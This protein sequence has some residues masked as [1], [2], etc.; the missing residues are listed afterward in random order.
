MKRIG[1]LGWYVLGC[2]VLAGTMAAAA[3]TRPL[4]F[5]HALQSKDYN[6]AAL[7]YINMLK[8]APGG[9]PQEVQQVLDLELS[10][11]YR[12][13]ANRA[14]DAKEFEALMADAQKHLDKF[15]KENAGHPEAVTASFSWAN[16]SVDRA[17]Q[18]LRV[19]QSL[20]EKKDA[21]VQEEHYG[22]ARKGLIDAK[23][24]FK[25]AIPKFLERVRALPPAP[26]TAKTKEDRKAIERREQVEGDYFNAVFQG[27]LCDYYIGQTYPDK[28]NKNRV[29]ALKEAAAVF[30]DIHQRKRVTAAGTVD[31]IGLYAHMWN[32]R[33][34]DELGDMTMAEDIYDEV[35]ANIP[36]GGGGVYGLEPLFAQVEH[37]RLQIVKAKEKTPKKFVDEA[38]EWL[39]TNKALGNTDG[40]QGI[41]L[42]L[43]K[44]YLKTAE[45]AATPSEKDRWMRM[46]RELLGGVARARS[47][48][49]KEAIVLRMSVTKGDVSDVAKVDKFAEAVA[50]AD[51]A[52]ASKQWDEALKGYQRAMELSSQEKDKAVVAKVGEQLHAVRLMQ[53]Y[54]LFG[55]GK[56]E[57]ALKL[58]GQVATEG[59]GS[60]SSAP[61][62]SA[63]AIQAALNLYVTSP[64]DKRDGALQRLV[65]IANYTIQK[66]PGK[67]EADE[68]RINLGRASLAQ[69]K[70][71]E[72]IATFEAVNPNSERYAGALQLA[73]R[74]YWYK[75]Q[76]ERQKQQQKAAFNEKQMEADHKRAVELLG[77]SY[78]IQV[79][80]AQRGG[81]SRDLQETTLALANIA[82]DE[83]KKPDGAGDPAKL[84][85]GA[86]YFQQLIDAQK[87]N[88]EGFDA[89]TL[90]IFIGA[91]NAYTQL[92]QLDKAAAAGGL[93]VESGPDTPQVNSVLIRF[94][95]TLNDQRK[96]AEAEVA[97]G[98]AAKKPEAEGMAKTVGDLMR[99][100]A[101]R[102]QQGLSGLVYI[103]DTLMATGAIAEA[104][105]LYAKIGERVQKEPAFAQQASG[106][107]AM[108]RVRS[109]LA[110]IMRKKAE[111]SADVEQAKKLYFEA[112][113][114]VAALLEA[115][116]NRALEP[117]MEK[118]R[119]LQS[120]GQKLKNREHYQ[121]AADHWAQLQGMLSGMLVK[122]KRPPEYYEV[123]YN[124]A[125]C[126]TKVGNGY[127]GSDK[128][129]AEE[130][131]KNAEKLLK[132]IIILTPKLSGEDMVVAYKA[133][134]QELAKKLEHPYIDP[135]P[136]A[137][138]AKP[139]EKKPDAAKADAAKAATTAEAKK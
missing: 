12:G 21:K 29:A 28:K 126:M 81:M 117:W 54:S 129:R 133:L 5:L 47:M 96:K 109:Q 32:G 73:G 49:Q 113:T 31:P 15:L 50:L 52:A 24:R 76:A 93:L 6:D 107:K 92:G 114:Q 19:A 38:T 40:Y 68:A 101:K 78:A 79:K 130:N 136:G 135:S 115:T 64:A 1:S 125:E 39:K 88:T 137:G 61:A 128:P 122:G 124:L 42:D 119:I 108:N 90:Q 94:A 85:E 138:E 9:L 27:A 72:A 83:S 102:Q 7:D 116:R 4:E 60:S 74:T 36:E 95:A 131:W 91:V 77:K 16:F 132:G 98:N 56:L 18:H 25:Q 104:E 30:D 70:V 103:A 100:L 118:G 53:A 111:Q 121:E 3:E 62:A 17:L 63:L 139:E 58:A 33:C 43:A 71:D 20:T 14:Y 23:P 66:W 84:A 44:T 112:L 120:R 67:P 86:K 65:N 48:Y 97:S 57:D 87:G 10:K 26:A 134:L 51:S 35:L 127:K 99:K 89:T 37:F 13:Q 8:A 110:G 69:G 22:E 46:A 105:E 82:M 55:D 80:S 34:H 2:A 41:S 11:C 45:A 75:Y 123:S 59:G 106:G